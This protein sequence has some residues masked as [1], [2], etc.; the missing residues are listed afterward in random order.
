MKEV[1]KGRIVTNE[2]KLKISNSLKGENHYNFG[3]KL[4]NETKNK[5]SESLK[6]KTQSKEWVEKRIIS[7]LKNKI[8]NNLDMIEK[9][10]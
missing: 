5:L 2:T 8:N 10:E 1:F 6:G 3:K 4:S 9:N 7:K